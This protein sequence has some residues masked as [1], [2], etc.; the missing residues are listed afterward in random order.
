MS[1]SSAGIFNLF[2][3]RLQF[4]E[5]CPLHQSITID[6]QVINYSTC[7]WL[8]EHNWRP[9]HDNLLPFEQFAEF[10]RKAGGGHF[11]KKIFVSYYIESF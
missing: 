3:T 5:I 1:V 10:R 2:I 7:Q 11:D 6:S 8:S 9:E 4:G